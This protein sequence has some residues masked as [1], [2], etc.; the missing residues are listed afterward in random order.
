MVSY[1]YYRDQG[2]RIFICKVMKFLNFKKTMLLQNARH[3]FSKIMR[4][5]IPFRIDENDFRV[6]II[7]GCGEAPA[8]HRALHKK[9]QL[10]LYGIK[11]KVV[12]SIIPEEILSYDLCIL[13]RTPYNDLI[14]KLLDKINGDNLLNPISLT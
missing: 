3:H 9:E 5:A 13:Q 6:L 4:A 2:W 11:C 10:D 8:R 12:Q 14:E 1:Y 7:R